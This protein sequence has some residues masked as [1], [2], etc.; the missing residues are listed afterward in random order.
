ML[1]VATVILCL[2]SDLGSGPIGLA[3]F[4]AVIAARQDRADG[5]GLFHRIKR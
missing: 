2:P 1:W 4:L 3:S 5:Y